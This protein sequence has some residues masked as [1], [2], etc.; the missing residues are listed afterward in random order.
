MVLITTSHRPTRR[1]RSLCNDL[2]R[3]IPGLTRVNRGK[4]NLI[5]VAEKAIQMNS[6]RFIIVDRWKGG[7]GR[8]RLFKISDEGVKENP[9][10]LYISGIRLRREFDIPREWIKEKINL[11]FLEGSKEENLEIEEFKLAISNFFGIPVLKE[12]AET[13]GYEAY[14]NIVAGEDCWAIMSFFRL[15]GKTEIG[16]RIKISHIVWDI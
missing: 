11:L 13:L 12:G 14:I 6:D 15:P 3:S 2:A 9:P 1:V 5:E 7:P 10:R 8:I 16:P 4:M